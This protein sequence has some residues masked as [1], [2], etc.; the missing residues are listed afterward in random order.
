[1]WLWVDAGGSLWVTADAKTSLETGFSALCRTSMDV[2]ERLWMAPRAGF[3]V[4]RKF[5]N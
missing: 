3:E 1:L 2:Y 5:L 4:G